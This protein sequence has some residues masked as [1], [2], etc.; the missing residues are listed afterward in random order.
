MKNT[1]FFA[2]KGGGGFFGPEKKG[3]PFFQTKLTVGQPN[4]VYEKE[5]DAV[6][7]KVVQRKPIFESKAEGPDEES[8]VRRKCAACEQEELQRKEEGGASQTISPGLEGSLHSSKGGGTP[9]PESTRNQMESSFGTDLGHVRVHDD[10]SAA[11]MSKGLNAQAFTHGSDIYFNSGKYDTGSKSG[12]HLLAHELTHVIQQGNGSLAAPVIRRQPAAGPPAAQPPATTSA[13]APP[14]LFGLDMAQTPNAVYFSV[15]LPGHPL[16]AIASYLYGSAGAADDLKKANSGIGDF[17]PGG[18]TLKPSGNPLTSDAAKALETNR[19][20]GSV[21]RTIGLP[22][23]SAGQTIVYT[24]NAP[25]AGTVQVTQQQMVS[26]LYGA[27]IWIGRQADY[28]SELLD[29]ARKIRNDYL[30]D[31]NSVVG[32]ISDESGD[33]SPPPESLWLDAINQASHIVWDVMGLNMSAFGMS[34]SMDLDKMLATRVFDQK[35]IASMQDKVKRNLPLLVKVAEAEH[36]THVQF[37][38]FIEGTIAGADKT[39]NRLEVTRNISFG[40][41]AGL[42]GAVAAPFVFGA[43]T[44][45]VG[46][47]AVGTVV[48]GGFAVTAGAEAGA[49][50]QGTLNVIAPG[51]EGNLS[52]KDRFVS[53]A[54]KGAVSGGLGAAGALVA[55][56]VSGAIGTKLFGTAARTGMQQTLVN[57]LTGAAIGAPSGVVS[58]AV[59][60]FS[61]WQSGKM[62]FWQYIENC[63]IG[64]GVGGALG[65]AFSLIPINGLYRSGGQ[66]FNPFRGDPVVPRFMLDGPWSPISR[67]WNPPPEFNALPPNRLPN[68]PEGYAWTRMDGR[69]EPI[70]TLGAFGEPLT[71]RPYTDANGRLDYNMLRGGKLL[72]SLAYT[73]PR[74]GTYQGGRNPPL[75]TNDFTEPDGTTWVLGHNVDHAD[76]PEG[77]GTINSDT[78]PA[79]YTPELEQWGTG[80]RRTLVGRVRK[81]GGSYRQ[82]NIYRQ[83]PRLTNNGTPIPDGVIFV[84][85]DPAGNPT[86]AYRVPF[87][88]NVPRQIDAFLAAGYDI[89]ISSLPPILTTARPTAINVGSSVGGAAGSENKNQ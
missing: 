17:V 5:A 84:T 89:P 62:T 74:G 6:A 19:K 4:D 59:E 46:T 63:G 13:S 22:G 31:R 28:Y 29:G 47:G 79:N 39:A 61:A 8:M 72:T 2:K 70:N 86:A 55:P 69:W 88:Q 32:W 54:K 25:G 81:A 77:P 57:V 34:A 60:N 41:A 73:R 51:K 80:P 78:D 56:G 40:I 83:T 53:G 12:E 67:G 20:N 48:A 38:A 50:T 23:K 65:G 52:V 58:A 36:D 68:L 14:V 21:L 35:D 82:I 16:A 9:L 10:N 37:H 45:L 33:V 15:T 26:L 27:L 85:Y 49:I 44:G 1:H 42:A 87:N 30:D 11:K 24:V 18:Q 43:V 7:D 66:P 75:T 64:A 76:T 71:L 3:T